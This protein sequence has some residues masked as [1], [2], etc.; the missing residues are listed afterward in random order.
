MSA[1]DEVLP[2]LDW[3]PNHDE[4]SRGFGVAEL[5]GDVAGPPERVS[6]TPFAPALDQ[7]REGACAGFATAGAVNVATIATHGEIGTGP[8]M[9][10]EEAALGLY[11]RAQQLDEWAGEDYSG[12]SVTAV[13]KAAREAQLITGYRWAFGTRQLAH[14]LRLGP[15]VIGIPWTSGM[16]RTDARGVVQVTGAKVGG[17][18]LVVTGF[19]PKHPLTGGA[20]FEWLNSWGPSYGRAGVGVIPAGSLGQLL[21]GIG[22][23]AFLELE[24]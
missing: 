15:A 6:W 12:T 3:M 9:L 18:A 11:K 1:L 19:D 8:F 5:V 2:V 22:E 13:M 24:P 21:A 16:Y 17:H 7:G 20:A 10:R 14:G 4:R 23:V